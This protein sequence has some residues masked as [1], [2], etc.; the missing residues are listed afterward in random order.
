MFF[1]YCEKRFTRVYPIFWLIM[2]PLIPAYYF[3]LGGQKSFDG[4]WWYVIKSVLLIPQDNLPILSVAWT[5]THEV[6][7]Y[8]LFALLI[9]LPRSISFPLL[10]MI[11][12]LSLWK[13]FM[14]YGEQ[15]HGSKY[16]TGATFLDQSMILSFATSRHTVQFFAGCLVAHLCERRTSGMS[17]SATLGTYAIF[18]LPFLSSVTEAGFFHEVLTNRSLRTIYYTLASGLVVYCSIQ[19]QFA[20]KATSPPGSLSKMGDS[21]YS[22]YLIHYPIILTFF[23][24]VSGFADS[25]SIY[26]THLFTVFSIVLALLGGWITYFYFE[27]PLLRISRNAFK[28][29]FLSAT[30]SHSSA[31]GT[32]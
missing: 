20:P 21:S 29:R 11:A 27:R 28:K 10:A 2:L 9:V 8:L 19:L 1:T 22:L 14:D 7:F 26:G 17:L 3:G 25:T 5:L 18:F 6:Y 30:Q 16:I 32:S 23:V 12:S 4:D 13:L 31:E 24:F 15:W